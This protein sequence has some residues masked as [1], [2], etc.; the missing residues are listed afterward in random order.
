[1][2]SEAGERERERTQEGELLE[3]WE[4]KSPVGYA[5]S[6]QQWPDERRAASQ[7]EREDAAGRARE[8]ADKDVWP[9]PL[10]P[11]L[12]LSGYMPLPP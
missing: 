7:R 1:M 10:A 12:S 9:F 4:G 5:V 8:E 11:S 6:R 3:S 2:A